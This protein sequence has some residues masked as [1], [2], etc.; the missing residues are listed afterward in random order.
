MYKKTLKSED[1]RG[2]PSE[3]FSKVL[4]TNEERTVELELMVLTTFRKIF[5]RVLPVPHTYRRA[6]YTS[7]RTEATETEPF[8]LRPLPRHVTNLAAH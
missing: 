1:E 4:G 5:S 8:L 3:P 6:R 2:S 7:F